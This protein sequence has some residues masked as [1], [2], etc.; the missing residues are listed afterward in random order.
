MAKNKKKKQKIKGLGD[1]VHAVTSALGIDKVVKKTFDAAG[2][3]CG[4]DERRKRW[5]EL[6]PFTRQPYD[7]LTENEFKELTEIFTVRGDVITMEMQKRLRKISDRIYRERT[8]MSSCGSCIRELHKKMK[9]IWEN[10]KEDERKN[11]D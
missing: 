8:E 4:C 3:D 9:A 7:C 10:Y 11:Q 2:L 6:V 5:N 1:A